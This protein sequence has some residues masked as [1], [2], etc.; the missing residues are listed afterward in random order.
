MMEKQSKID[1]LEKELSRLLNW[2]T[3][4]ESKLNLVITLSTAMLGALAVLAS[5]AEGWTCYSI[6]LVLITASIL[7][8]V[9]V[10]SASASFPRIGGPDES[11]IFFGRISELSSEGYSNQI[12]NLTEDVYVND[13]ISQC[14]RN[15]EIATTKYTWVKRAITSLFISLPPWVLSLYLLFNS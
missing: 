4:A 10:F 12:L 13:L 3:A 9:L 11:L 14:H 6:L 15:A 7:I 5:S 1:F 8:S 2:I